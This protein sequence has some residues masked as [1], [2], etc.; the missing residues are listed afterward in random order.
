MLEG[1]FSRTAIGAAGHRAAH[2]VLDGASLFAD[3]FATRILGKDLESALADGRDPARRR[4]RLFI[5]LR[6]RIAEDAARR[7]IDEG[8]RQIVVLGAGLDTFGYRIDPV[9]SLRVLEVDHP[10]TQAEKRRRL[11]ET[12]IPVPPD[13]IY[14]PCDF[15]TQSLGQALADAGFDARAAAFFIWLGVT[16]YLTSDAVEATLSFVAG[17][18]GGAEIVFDYVNPTKSIEAEEARDH[19][20]RLAA[21][22]AALGEQFRGYFETADLHRRLAAFG[23][24][25]IEDWG[26]RRIRDRL[27]PG[28]PRSDDNGGHILRAARRV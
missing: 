16:P 12:D 15:E 13:L 17:L 20:E 5:A 23:F 24:D 11:A 10:A 19:H 25:E 1:Q 22:V 9:D 28:Y 2:Q 26:P 21:R 6:S 4:L 14:A 18:P 8:V 27:A 7:A 3:P